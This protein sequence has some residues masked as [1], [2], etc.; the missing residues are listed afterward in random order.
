LITQ[1]KEYPMTIKPRPGNQ[2]D[3]NDMADAFAKDGESSN[4]AT[5]YPNLEAEEEEAAKLGDF[6]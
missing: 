4:A 5:P 2:P 6:A 3:S 1:H